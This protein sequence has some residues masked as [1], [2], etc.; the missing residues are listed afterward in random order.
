MSHDTYTALQT[1][2]KALGLYTGRIDGLW[3]PGSINGFE[4]ARSLASFNDQTPFLQSY[5]Q[6]SAW[7][8][9]V[10]DTFVEKTREICQKLG[11]RN[12]DWMMAA[13]AFESGRTFSPTIQNGAGAPY[14]GIIQFGAAAAKDAGTSIP[15]LLKMTAEEQLDYVYNF[16]RPYANRI[17]TLSD[18]YMRIL[19]PRAVGRPESYVLWDEATRPTTY[20]QNRGLDRNRDGRITK[21][22]AALT[23]AKVLAEGLDPVNLRPVAV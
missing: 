21:A 11:I 12:S 8:D 19:W 2:L 7:S 6:A 20:R 13:M 18:L 23:V 22:E 3:G 10:S 5:A 4:E 15:E 1:D 14:Y 16:F 9:K 17:N